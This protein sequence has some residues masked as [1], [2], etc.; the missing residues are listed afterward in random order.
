M[1]R[2]LLGLGIVVLLVAAAPTLKLIGVQLGDGSALLASGERQRVKQVQLP[3]QRGSILDRNGAELAISVPRKRVV[4]NIKRLV[5]EGI[6]DNAGMASLAKVIAVPLDADPVRLAKLMTESE[7]DDPWVRLVE[8]APEDGAA[9]ALEAAAD[10]GVI[11]AIT[12]ENSSERVH[13]AGDSGL[14]IMGA[15][16]PDGPSELAGIERGYNEDLEGRPGRQAVEKGHGPDGA[17]IVGSERT[18][19][20]ARAGSDV[21][22]TLDRTLQHEVE[23]SLL[24]GTATAGAVRGIAVVGRPGTGEILAAGSVERDDKTGEMRLSLGP[25]PVS[26]A[27]QAGSV[28]KLVTVAAAVE[29]GAVAADQSFE[30]PYQIT[31]DDRRFS[32][33]EPHGT[34]TMTVTD[35]VAKSS[36]VGTIKIGQELGA[37]ALRNALVGFGFGAK[38]GVGH[39]AE[40][41]GLLPSLDRWTRPDLAAS[42]IGTH[43]SATALQLWAAYNVIANKGTYVQPR[44]VDAVINPDGTER[45]VATAE[46]RRVIS[47]KT[48]GEVGSMLEEVMKEGTG[49]SL[50]LPGYS[51]AAKTGT[52]RLVSPERVDP[53]DS[54]LW[55]D[56]RYHYV[57]AFTGY[58][59]ADRPAVSITVILEDTAAGLTGATAAGPV[60]ASLG[61]LAIRELGIAPTGATELPPSGMVR[62]EPAG[63]N[64]ASVEPS[65]VKLASTK[66]TKSPEGREPKEQATSGR[67][68][69]PSEEPD[70]EESATADEEP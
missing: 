38:T 16:G 64:A 15:L 43:Q 59:P 11:T 53:A 37:E 47:E 20:P 46:P 52:S 2:R 22:M 32:D 56:G 9:A 36:N 48:A 50:Q 14:R 4:I 55:A 8:H 27:Y 28:F 31:V 6:E 49:R 45:R 18:L 65:T 63:T 17:T 54:Y 5:E 12:L 67:S 40:S 42:S 39:P 66:A 35:I 13:P 57:T 60:F 24:S 23:Q 21:R 58:L 10:M 29:S 19:E 44:L 7:R 34:E 3:A 41:S 51:V 62:A 30:V 1:R 68:S 26:N 61:R 25:A 33:S 69:S 70:G